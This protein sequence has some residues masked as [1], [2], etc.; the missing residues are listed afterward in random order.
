MPVIDDYP[1]K[2]TGPE[3]HRLAD[4]AGVHMDLRWTSGTCAQLGRRIEQ[5]VDDRSHEAMHDAAIIRYARCFSGGKR[6][7]FLVPPEWISD[8]PPELH[9]MHGFVLK[10]RDKHIA[11]SI[12]D[13]ELNT[14][15]ARVRINRETGHAQVHAVSVTQQ[16]VLMLSSDSVRLLRQLAKVLADRAELELKAEQARLLEHA[17]RIPIEELKRRIAEDRG[18]FPG[19]RK[20][21]NAR[22]R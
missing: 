7:A 5:K 21:G 4:L 20:V 12:N 8:L 1:V 15:V 10:L 2:L 13:W 14:P 17:K 11:H 16:R 18:D 9:E 6:T 19:R 22:G 3:T